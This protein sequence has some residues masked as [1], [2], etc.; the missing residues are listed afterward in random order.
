MCQSQTPTL[1]TPTTPAG[2]PATAAAVSQGCGCG[3]HATQAP[4][5]V[6]RV[7]AASHELDFPEV[8]FPSARVLAAAGAEGL[9]RLVRRHHALLRQSAIGPL[10]AADDTV[11]ATLVER[12][13][14]YVVEACGG[15]TLFSQAHGQTCMRTRHFPFNIDENGRTV[16]LQNLFQAMEETGFPEALR[17]E[18]WFWMEAFTIR[19]INRRTTKAQPERIPFALARS[20]YST[21]EQS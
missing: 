20:R 9:R 6:G 15:P 8:P 17:E 2:V 14:D 5:T 3:G 19:M 10:F 11:F 16:W 21:L 18:Y 12:I 4:A 13:G 7:V 1:V